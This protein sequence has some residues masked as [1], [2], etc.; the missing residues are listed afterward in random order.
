[1]I[2]GAVGRRAFVSGKARLLRRCGVVWRLERRGAQG[3]SEV[4]GFYAPSL[5]GMVFVERLW[6]RRDRRCGG[7]VGVEGREEMWGMLVSWAFVV[8]PAEA[9]AR[10]EE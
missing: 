1:M 10:V 2:R 5:A 8:S 3:A 9:D 6:V 7:W 4:M